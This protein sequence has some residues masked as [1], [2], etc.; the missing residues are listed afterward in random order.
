MKH[1]EARIFHRGLDG[2][3]ERGESVVQLRDTRLQALLVGVDGYIGD[4]VVKVKVARHEA[5]QKQRGKQGC[6]R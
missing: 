6:D 2:V 1:A 4:V 5:Q 3:V